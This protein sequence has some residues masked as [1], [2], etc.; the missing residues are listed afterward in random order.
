MKMLTGLYAYSPERVCRFA[1]QCRRSLEL[2]MNNLENSLSFMG[3]AEMWELSLLILH[4][5]IRGACPPIL[6]EFLLSVKR[7]RSDVPTYRNTS[8]SLRESVL[9][10]LPTAKRKKRM[11]RRKRSSSSRELEINGKEGGNSRINNGLEYKNFTAIANETYRNELWN[12]N[13]LDLELYSKA[14]EL[15]CKDV[16]NFNLWEDQTI[17]E[18]WKERS[19][20]KIDLCY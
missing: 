7:E 19:P 6:S 16:H 18:Y 11:G 3:I 10:F 2:A 13:A 20:I 14:L 5:K 9:G 12:Q 4:L 1:R 17:R 15:L 8:R